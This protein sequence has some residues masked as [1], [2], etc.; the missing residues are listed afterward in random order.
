MFLTLSDAKHFRFRSLFAKKSCL[1]R[2]DTFLIGKT[3]WK[4]TL[5]FSMT[6][7]KRTV[8]PLRAI[9]DTFACFFHS[10]RQNRSPFFGTF[11]QNWGKISLSISKIVRKIL[12]R[13]SDPPE[14]RTVW[15]RQT[16][17][18]LFPNYAMFVGSKPPL[19]AFQ[20]KSSLHTKFA[21]YVQLHCQRF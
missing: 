4:L 5:R 1:D 9:F 17:F 3:S 11:S 10:I 6:P 16:I 12:L 13:F 8:W 19:A 7:V 18:G 15:A 14:K 21:Q 20:S 2:W